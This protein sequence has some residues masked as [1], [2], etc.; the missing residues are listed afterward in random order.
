MSD[1]RVFTDY[2]PNCELNATLQKKY[3]VSNSHKYRAFLQ[4]NSEQVK[5]DLFNC[6]EQQEDCKLCPVCKKAVEYKP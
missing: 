6:Q 5:K 2:N 1:A 4:A 3:N